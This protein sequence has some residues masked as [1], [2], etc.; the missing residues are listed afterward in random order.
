MISGVFKK[1]RRFHFIG[2]G[3]V[4]MSG[5]ARFC[6]KAGCR[7]SGSDTVVSDYTGRLAESGVKIF[8]GHARKNVR[9]A[10]V[11]IY[12]SAIAEDNPE[13]CAARDNGKLIL[14]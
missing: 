3:G 2:I 11:V 1:N 10:E 7:V 8:I 13:L 12:N 9:G 6:L 5:L 4:S 14:K